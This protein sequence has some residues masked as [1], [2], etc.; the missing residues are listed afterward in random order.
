MKRLLTI[1]LFLFVFLDFSFAQMQDIESIVSRLTKSLNIDTITPRKYSQIANTLSNSGYYHEALAIIKKAVKEEPK[2]YLNVAN[3]DFNLGLIDDAIKDITIY[4]NCQKKDFYGYYFRGWCYDNF[5][6]YDEAIKNYTQAIKLNSSY[7]YAYLGRANMSRVTN[8]SR[9]AKKDYKKVISLEPIPNA[10]SCL[11]YAY[12]FLGQKEKAKRIMDAIITIYDTVGNNYDAACLYADMNEPDSALYYL[13]RA[14]KKGYKR[15][16]H[17]M[18]DDDLDN[19]R[20]DQRYKTIMQ[21]Y[22]RPWKYDKTPEEILS[23][24]LKK[25]DTIEDK[26]DKIQYA[27]TTAL[28]KFFAFLHKNTEERTVNNMLQRI[29]DYDKTHKKPDNKYAQTVQAISTL[30]GTEKFYSEAIKYRTLYLK[31]KKSLSGCDT[32]YASNLGIL[33]GYYTKVGDYHHAIKCEK[34]VASIYKKFLG[35]RNLRYAKS[36]NTLAAYYEIIS[37]FP[38]ALELNKR[39]LKIVE[40]ASNDHKNKALAFHSISG[41]YYCMG[42]YKDAIKYEKQA[43]E[44]SEKEKKDMFSSYYSSLSNMAL[45][46]SC[47][48]DYKKAIVWETLSYK[49]TPSMNKT[50]DN[51][52]YLHNM[53]YYSSMLGNYENAKRLEI[54]NLREYKDK[55]TN[56]YPNYLNRLSDY[57]FK[58]GERQKAVELCELAKDIIETNQNKNMSI[59][60][61]IL[62]NLS[63]YDSCLGKYKEGL[64][65]EEKNKDLII[66]FWG[67]SSPQ[68]INALLRLASYHQMVGDQKMATSYV[69]DFS[70]LIRQ[71]VHDNFLWLTS[72]ERESFWDV[73]NPILSSTIPHLTY[74][75]QTDSL[76]GV[77]YDAAILYKGILLNTRKRNS[78]RL[79]WIVAISN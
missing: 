33:A 59:Y 38:K 54:Q 50:L 63:Y 69:L 75:L 28:G 2:Y 20:G 32:I 76:Y 57:C 31:I 24:I 65:I 52:L 15:I 36:L 64:T 39:F 4:I 6:K 66:T 12:L 7:T 34:R 71:Y 44:I 55:N 8:K 74:Q 25:T 23:S 77:C 79:L 45:Y 27:D 48:G 17:V 46:Y 3:I 49:L 13:E 19:I 9:K 18:Q 11:Q 16:P 40:Y 37:D 42:D 47:L 5:R 61:G 22:S 35:E 51:S 10:N 78:R 56:I 58:L 72:D 62:S 43:L 60:T 30:F 70:A 14:L 73:Y 53:A 1:I 26:I 41:N 67:K 29:E 68:Y 21:R